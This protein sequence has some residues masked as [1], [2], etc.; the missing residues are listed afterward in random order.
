[1]IFTYSGRGWI[2]I[3]LF[4]LAFLLTWGISSL[5]RSATP[6][7]SLIVSFVAVAIINLVLARWVGRPLPHAGERQLHRFMFLPM[8][9]WSLV[10]LAL[11][12]MIAWGNWR[13]ITGAP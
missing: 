9:W 12:A 3:V 7:I 4:F 11:A 2:T 10:F 8:E 13:E 6:T 1:M 5:W